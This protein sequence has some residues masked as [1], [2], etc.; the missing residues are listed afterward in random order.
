VIKSDQV[1]ESENQINYTRFQKF[2]KKWWSQYRK[3]IINKPTWSMLKFGI[4]T[5]SLQ[6]VIV[7][8]STALLNTIIDATAGS[9]IAGDFLRSTP[10]PLSDVAAFSFAWSVGFGVIADT[11][12]AWVNIPGSKAK[13]IAKNMLNGVLFA[14]VL[15]LVINGGNFASAFGGTFTEFILSQGKIFAGRILSN[16]YKPN[17]YNFAILN[18]RIGKTYGKFSLGPIKTNWNTSLVSFNMWYLP[19]YLTSYLE[20][21]NLLMAD[22][23]PAG[24]VLMALSIPFSEYTFMK[25][26]QSVAKK[27]NHPEAIRMAK[28][29]KDSWN[30]KFSFLAQPFQFKKNLINKY[31]LKKLD[32]NNSCSSLMTQFLYTAH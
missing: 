29:A 10:I 7:V 14:Q 6:S 4:F 19:A 12:K 23:I 9:P 28:E 21:T 17:Y 2:S 31:K 22:R 13:K 1:F 16:S 20:R 5:A 11:F 18:E 26:A 8:S 30:R 3:A 25:Y 32:K 27:T 15:T 24:T